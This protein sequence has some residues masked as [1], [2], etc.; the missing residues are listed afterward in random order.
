LNIK[1][2]NILIAVVPMAVGLGILLGLN[3]LSAPKPVPA[4]TTVALPAVDSSQAA[5]QDPTHEK[6]ALEAELKKKPG[7]PPILL[8]L[9]EMEQ[10]AGQATK[11]TSYLK[12]LVQQDPGNAEGRLELGRALF[13]AGDID[14]A[15]R[16]TERLVKD[17]PN[18][19]DGLYN[20]GAIY[21]NVNK[22]DEARA[23]WNRAVAAEPGSESGQKAQDGLAK[24]SGASVANHLPAGHPTIAK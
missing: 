3:R 22:L 18:H 17:N 9:A 1:V 19:V 13:D 20:L 24:I 15:I 11:A 10:A 2:R 12:E 16:E 6:A 8:R 7:H 21:A 4:S 5:P 14:G 23:Y